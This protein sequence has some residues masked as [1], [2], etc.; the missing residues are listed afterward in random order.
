MSDP[1]S[2]ALNS[3]TGENSAP[4]SV[5]AALQSV[6]S[7]PATVSATPTP[8]EP[9]WRKAVGWS[10]APF[11]ANE[12][13]ASQIGGQ[14]AGGLVGLG[15]WPFVGTDKAADLVR[16]TEDALT[17]NPSSPE[18]RAYT[19]AIGK[20]VG[21]DLNPMNWPDVIGRKAG[22][23]S[24][25]LG[26]PPSVST[27]LRIAPDAA[28]MLWGLRNTPESPKAPPMETELR[29]GDVPQPL[30]VMPAERGAPSMVGE[31]TEAPA[32]THAPF[33]EPPQAAARGELPI[34]E[35]ARR[36]RVL[37]EVGLGGQEIRKSAITGDPLAA[38]T[39][40]QVAKFDTDAGRHARSVLDTE[41]NALG[42][43]AQ[44]IVES[45]G[46]RMGDTQTDSMARGETVQN[47]L[48]QLSDK[49]NTRIG[50]LYQDADAA[51]RAGR[52]TSYDPK[53][54]ATSLTDLSGV[55][56]LLNQPSFKN[57][58]MA[59]DQQ[60][61]LGAVKNQLDAFR[62]THPNGFMAQDAEQF[63]QWL[64][65]AWSP[66]NSWAIGKIKDAVDEDV[67]SAAGEDV[68]QAARALRK[69][70]ADVMENPKGISAL[71]D[72]S[73]PNGINRV[74]PA[75]NVMSK[76][77]TMPVG[78]LEHV[79]DTLRGMNT[80][81][82]KQAMSDIQAHFAERLRQIGESHQVQWNSK[83]VNQY[84]KNNSTRLQTVFQD[85]P[86]V[87]QRFY[88]LNEAGKILR[89]D[90]S[91]PG[92]AAQAVNAAKSGTIPAYLHRGIT[93]GG[94]A[95]GGAVGGPLGAAAGEFV[96]NLAGSKA[97]RVAADK[98]ALKAARSRTVRLG[99]E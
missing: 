36:A 64:N 81:E 56:K 42:T 14:I 96:G 94:S 17:Y 24:S 52:G 38:G 87:L 21:S 19:H 49:Y 27:A 69:E 45:T 61:L 43:Y 48:E 12:H 68:Y 98:A 73:G 84:L 95:L 28:A 3:V 89:Y 2:D 8:V 51:A 76:L 39:D 50:Q 83:G 23:F 66:K 44:Q 78:Q 13:Y 35:Q 70:R 74:V 85:N 91:Y 41:R 16:S 97:A 72:S 77:E 6:G 26:A 54:G 46:G 32:A 11:Q 20:V 34:A 67:T 15:A 55:D 57:A 90:S 71:I 59:K 65:Q 62:E 10:L 86:Q 4:D 60:G 79:T 31:T 53:T 63:R 22:D 9:F 93:M 92:A 75:E 1:V 80:P 82:A 88:T 47:A 58:L 40:A 37:N 25:D 33:E 5:S 18:G 7:Q 30:E 29:P 99:G